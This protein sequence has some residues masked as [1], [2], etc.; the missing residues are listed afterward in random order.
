MPKMTIYIR[1]DGTMS[2]TEMCPESKELVKAEGF[3]VV[4]PME[5]KDDGTEKQDD[6]H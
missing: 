4:K 1:K 2:I 5:A 3:K 6:N